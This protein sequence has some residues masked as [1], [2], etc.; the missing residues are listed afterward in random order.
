MWKT[1]EN[2]GIFDDEENSE[3]NETKPEG[4]AKGKKTRLYKWREDL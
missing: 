4:I 3:D 1:A 2:A